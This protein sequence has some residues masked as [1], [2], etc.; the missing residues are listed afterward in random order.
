LLVDVMNGERYERD[1]DEMLD[2]GLY[3]DLE[4]WRFHFLHWEGT[5]L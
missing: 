5:V 1:G 2:Q 4:A 3:V